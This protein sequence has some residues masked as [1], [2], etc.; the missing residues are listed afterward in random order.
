MCMKRCVCARFFATLCTS[1]YVLNAVVCF[2][3]FFF[4]SF[5][6]SSQQSI[7]RARSFTLY[8]HPC[9][10]E[11]V[12]T[13][14]NTNT[15]IRAIRN[16]NNIQ[17]VRTHT[18]HNWQCSVRTQLWLCEPWQK[19]NQI[20]ATF[21][22]YE[23]YEQ[24]AVECDSWVRRRLLIGKRL[25]KYIVALAKFSVLLFFSFVVNSVVDQKQQ[26]NRQKK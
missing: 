19:A 23:H 1:C 17:M 6:S 18:S 15:R 25:K 8:D 22:I 26:T 7:S 9:M 5:K 4:F 2:I 3:L 21:R 10:C 11:W 24:F 13:E 16:A 20:A 14:L 12:S